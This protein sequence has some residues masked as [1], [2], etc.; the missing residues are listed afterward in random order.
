MRTLTLS[1]LFANLALSAACMFGDSTLFSSDKTAEEPV[2]A[3]LAI[4]TP[5]IEKPSIAVPTIR[6]F[7]HEMLILCWQDG[8]PI[9][10][11][12]CPTSIHQIGLAPI[13]AGP[14]SLSNA[15]S[16]VS[17]LDTNSQGEP[18]GEIRNITNSIALP[19]IQIPRSISLHDPQSK[20]YRA[21]IAE[22]TQAKD[23]PIRVLARVD[24][25]GNGS[26]EVLFEVNQDIDWH[27][28]GPANI[29]SLVGIRALIN[30]DVK[31]LLLHDEQTS[32]PANE[33]IHYW[34][35]GTLEGVTDIDGDGRLE[36]VLGTSYYEGAAFSVY[37]FDGTQFTRLGAYGCGA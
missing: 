35:K 22:A 30:G 12:E 2:V 23:T 33:Q 4:R 1:V 5:E 8:K 14:I 10:A 31:T 37:S 36:I 28:K 17:A 19:A 32:V 11:K 3:P 27:V 6:G 29:V 24:L 18:C 34:Q 20:K 16:Q 15:V 7:E 21:R 9:D 26:E 13:K 25:D